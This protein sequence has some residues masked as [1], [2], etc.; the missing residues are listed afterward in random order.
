MKH[1]LKSAVVIILTLE[2][3]ILLK[4]TKPTIVAVTGNVGKTSTKDAIYHVLKDSFQARKSEKSYNSEIGVPLS[5]LGLHN[6]WSNPILWFRNIFNGLLQIIFPYNYPKIL[7]LEMGV[8]RPGDMKKLTSWIKPDIVVLTR[9][10]EVPVHVEYFSSPEEVVKEKLVLVE[11]LKDNG[12]LIFNND[13]EQVRQAA[14]SI[15]QKSFSYSR[16]S[17]S[18]FYANEDKIIYKDAKPVGIEFDIKNVDHE[19]SFS[20]QNVV[21]TAHIYAIT[22]AVAVAKLFDIDLPKAADKLR[23]FEAPIGRMHIIPGVKNTTIIDDTYNSSP[24]ALDRALSTL[25]EIKTTGHRYAVIG[26]MLE[27]GRFSSEAHI[28]AGVQAYECCDKLVTVGV[29]ARKVAEGALDAGMDEANILQYD[30]SVSAGRELQNL[31]QENDVILIKGSQGMR[32]ERIV[33][34]IMEEPE[35]ADQLVVRQSKKWLAKG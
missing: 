16:Y 3:K 22:A 2:A 13:D 19:A 9:L 35:Q 6:A 32:M 33:T 29:R 11:A 10:P 17:L 7:I 5:V 18:D 26:D 4:R 8:D 21:G 30:D 28:S 20:L 31:I 15:R 23:D 27:L 1:L 25:K 34:D 14:T 12:I 24:T